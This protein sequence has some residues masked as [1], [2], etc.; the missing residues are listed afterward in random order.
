VAGEP[1]SSLSGKIAVVT[2]ATEGIGKAVAVRLSSDGA[3][4]VLVARRKPQL[5]GVQR[6]IQEAGGVA[7]CEPADLRDPASISSLTSRLIE[8]HRRI[9]ILVNCGGSYHRG[10]WMSAPL[11]D[12]DELYETNV[13]GICQLT[14][15][16]LPAMTGNGADIV[17][18]NS[19]IVFSDGRN[20]S[21]YAATQH[22]LVGLADSLRAEVNDLG[23]RV[24]SIYPGRTATPRQAGIFQAEGKPYHPER[25]LQPEDVAE[26]IA[27]CLTL[28]ATAE[29]TDL[30]IRPR[31][32]H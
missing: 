24:L 6:R 18:V 16:L 32:K 26:A 21:H 31:N 3:R 5:A 7:H 27:A 15:G 11:D 14:Q 19:T 9:D 1:Q 29:V 17:F 30:R 2:G 20:T 12:L 4:V 10:E 8:T 25:L 28:A 13:R 23:I 22:A